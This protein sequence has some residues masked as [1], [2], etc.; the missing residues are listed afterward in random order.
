MKK[1]L[2]LL[3]ICFLFGCT[4][5]VKIEQVSVKQPEEK[6]EIVIKEEK[7]THNFGLDEHFYR[8]AYMIQ[9]EAIPNDTLEML[10]ETALQN[11]KDPII[12]L[13][14]SLA[15]SDGYTDKEI[16]TITDKLPPLFIE[17]KDCQKEI[18]SFRVFQ[19]LTDKEGQVYGALAFGR[20]KGYYGDAPVFFFLYNF[21]DPQKREILYDDLKITPK[22]TD[23][24]V[25][26]GTFTYTTKA[27]VEK[28]IP[29]VKIDEDN[30][31]INPDY[32]LAVAS[33]ILSVIEKHPELKQE[34][35]N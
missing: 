21:R 6:R 13:F 35:T 8:A 1:L 24:V 10:M 30:T 3:A 15:T 20:E 33:I 18:E 23:C 4:H 32:K 26:Y 14:T 31:E 17:R 25:Y 11:K 9:Q 34:E 22:A 16:K 12:I 19:T 29:K 28:T 2:A 27:N 7:V 5:Q